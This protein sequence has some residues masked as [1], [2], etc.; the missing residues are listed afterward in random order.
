VPR[1]SPT[2]PQGGRGTVTIYTSRQAIRI[3][4]AERER[5]RLI[6]AW[7]WAGPFGKVR[8]RVEHG[9]R[10]PMCGNDASSTSAGDRTESS[11]LPL[12]EGDDALG[13]LGAEGIVWGVA[14]P[15][16]DDGRSET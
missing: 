12:F 10:R 13:G 7:V 14:A 16:R 2:C 6:W 5:P 11:S 1:P 3:N 8:I 9:A 4:A 15:R